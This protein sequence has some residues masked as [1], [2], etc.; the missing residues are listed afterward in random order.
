MLSYMNI[1]SILVVGIICAIIVR[2]AFEQY[3]D[4][5]MVLRS[6]FQSSEF[7]VLAGVLIFGFMIPI[8]S[9]R[10]FPSVTYETSK[11]VQYLG[12]FAMI[13]AIIVFWR[14]HADLGRQYSPTLQIKT[15]HELVTSGI[16]KYVRHPMYTSAFLLILSSALIN[17][18]MVGVSSSLLAFLILLLVRIPKEEQMLLTEFSSKYVNYIS[19]MCGIIP[20]L[21]KYF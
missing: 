20:Y 4:Q 12:V 5:N 11:I 2:L 15:N 16:Y 9:H 21:C 14:A 7:Y 1:A 13:L 18:N 6:Y 19:E 17:P 3:N 8:I 10:V